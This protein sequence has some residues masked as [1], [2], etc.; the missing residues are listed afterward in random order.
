[1]YVIYEL[2]LS[3]HVLNQPVQN[4][5]LLFFSNVQYTGQNRGL[6]LVWYYILL[7]FNYWSLYR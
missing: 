1:M 3:W 5:Q 2:V 4:K 7:I 6:E